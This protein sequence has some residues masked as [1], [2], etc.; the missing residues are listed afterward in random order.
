MKVTYANFKQQFSEIDKAKLPK[1]LQIPENDLMELHEFYDDDSDI[2]S[3]FDAYL[4]KL[5]EF[6]SKKDIKP[7]SKAKKV[8]RLTK[9]AS[10]QKS[11][12]K[13][14]KKPLGKKARK[15]ENPCQ[16][17]I[18]QLNDKTKR[19]KSKPIKIA[20]DI[21]SD[22]VSHFN[23]DYRLIRRFYN[24]VKRKKSVAF[25]SIQLVYM[26]FQ[27]GALTR[28]VRKSS[29]SNELYEK[30]SKKIA[31]LFEAA[32]ENKRPTDITVKD[33]DFFKTLETFIN[34]KN[35]NYAVQLISRVINLRGTSPDEDKVKRLVV[36]I[37]NA[38]S[39]GKITEKN[40]LYK[41]LKKSLRDL[42]EYQ[43]GKTDVIDIEVHG[44]T[45]V[46]KKN[47]KI[48]RVYLP[49]EVEPE[50]P[51]KEV[52]NRTIQSP[53]PVLR[54]P[55]SQHIVSS[56]SSEVSY[57]AQKNEKR[58][59][60]KVITKK[61]ANSN[62]ALESLGFV[63]AASEP[64][65]VADTYVLPGE[66]GKFLQISQ[67]HKELIIVKG[68]KHSSKSQ[69]VMQIADAYG[70]MGHQ[71]AYIDYEQGG[72]KSKDTKDSRNRNTTPQGVDN[73]MITGHLDNPYEDLRKIA[74]VSA[75]I[76]ADSVTDLGISADQL[77]KLREE[78]IETTWI[79]ISQVKENG[80]MYGGG[81]MAH[82]PTKIIECHSD[83]DYRKRYATLEKNR[84]NDLAMCYQIFEKRA[85]REDEVEETTTSN[86]EADFVVVL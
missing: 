54:T 3:T 48:I 83:K 29:K 1:N 60:P 81:K 8:S 4:K 42:K 66:I 35:I 16:E 57:P 21:V 24:L 6:L 68:K 76:A 28:K 26:A 23:E 86:S 79:F 73:I 13:S 82:N 14:R 59:S 84:G 53:E 70:Q 34:S 9:T 44:L 65:D 40:R 58:D 64:E 20:D 27:K 56:R 7:A 10:K 12:R 80:Q 15:R 25:R 2:K 22:T 78:Y 5:N 63:N 45:G 36:T 19:K 61:K 47:P 85:Y 32:A 50:P 43:K 49:K 71:V 77:N 72:L 69:L 46:Q 52:E 62:N 11:K 51:E 37:E 67:P 39:K 75:V 30:C 74:S 17:F 41:E 38:I 33:V 18:D 55:P 31:L